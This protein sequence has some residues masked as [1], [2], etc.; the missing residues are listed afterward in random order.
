MHDMCKINAPRVAQT[1]DAQFEKR[2][3]E[4]RH[5]RGLSQ[6]EPAQR[7]GVSFQQVQKYERGRNRFS[8]ARLY[9]VC[10]VMGVPMTAVFEGLDA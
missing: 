6:A 8:A 9:E 5:E 10:N 1:V 3:R 7:I 4:L 2:V